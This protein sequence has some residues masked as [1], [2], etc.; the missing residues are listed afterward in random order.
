M[1]KTKTPALQ[2]GCFAVCS[3][4]LRRHWCAF[5][6][7]DDGDVLLQLSEGY[8]Q[9]CLLGQSGLVEKCRQYGIEG[10]TEM[11]SRFDPRGNQ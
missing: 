11:W 3:G 4:W 5:G 2:G 1:C 10:L 7:G 6:V 9:S 8:F